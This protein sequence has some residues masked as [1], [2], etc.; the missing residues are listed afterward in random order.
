VEKAHE[1]PM[2]EAKQALPGM[3]KVILPDWK[4]VVHLAACQGKS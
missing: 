3:M 2:C 1:A 4:P